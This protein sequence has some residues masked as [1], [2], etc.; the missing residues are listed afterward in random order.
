[1]LNDVKLV[2]S[3]DD[4]KILDVS[5]AL[6]SPQRLQ[7]LRLLNKNSYTVK[8]LSD[9]LKQPLSSTLLN[10]NILAEAGIVNIKE[11]IS[12]QGKSKLV[13]RIADLVTVTLFKEVTNSSN[14]ITLNIPIGNYVSYDISKKTSCGIA[15]PEKNIGIDNDTDVF[16]SPERFRAGAIWFNSGF[17]E[18]RV[19]NKML[20]HKLKSLSLSFE[21]CSEA[22]FYRNDW[23]SDITVIINGKEIGTWTSLG[24]YGGRPGKNNPKWWPEAI[25]QFGVLT[26]WEVNSLGTFVNSIKVSNTTLDELIIH[27]RDYISIKIG[28]KNDAKNVGG[29]NLFGKTFGDYSQDINLS[30]KW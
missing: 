9:I 30:F 21:V 27:E 4:L 23:K 24:D 22:P 20:P 2:L 3:E 6:S 7:I 1:M 8:E 14:N 5:R 29:I 26:T 19:S 13:D 12:K 16:F 28:V 25:T 17:L 15:T 18:Y 11:T 10:V